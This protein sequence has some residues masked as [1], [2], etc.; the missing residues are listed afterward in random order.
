MK[1]ALPI[2]LAALLTLPF[3]THLTAMVRRHPDLAFVDMNV[4]EKG[5]PSFVA[6]FVAGMGDQMDYTVAVGTDD[7]HMAR[8]WLD[9]AGQAG[10]P[11]VFVVHH[12]QIAGIGHPMLGL[13]K[14]LDEL[15]DGSFDLDRVKTLA[16]APKHVE[17]LL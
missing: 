7:Q 8:S 4:W 15:A 9:A 14:V 11:V 10:I 3:T 2:F 13:D 6:D 5:K 16:A 17:K 12:G 1:H